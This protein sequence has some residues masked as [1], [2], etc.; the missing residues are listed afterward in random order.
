MSLEVEFH[1]SLTPDQEAEWT[2]FWA[3]CQHSHPR[4]HVVFG[5][6]ERAKGRTPIFVMAR[7]G[8]SLV[9]VGLFSIRP[10]WWLGGASLEAV[11]QRG[12]IF[13]DPKHL[14]ASIS[15][16]VSGFA[17]L[18]V[19][20]LSVSPR[21]EAPAGAA[22]ESILRKGGFALRWTSRGPVGCHRDCRSYTA[23]GRDPPFIL[24]QHPEADS[25]CARERRS[26]P[27]RRQRYRGTRLLQRAPAYACSPWPVSGDST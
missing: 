8:A 5:Q 16:I 20:T 15:P 24:R 23:R 21:W 13:D 6:V 27:R 2:R 26:L 22:V 4:Q 18:N 17:Q 7:Q 9:L 12:P 25:P 19:G 1:H 14:A 11:C 10:H 3:T